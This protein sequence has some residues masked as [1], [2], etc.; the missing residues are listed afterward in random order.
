MSMREMPLVSVITATY[1]NFDHLKETMLSVF[2]QDYPYIE[3]IIT[4]DGSVDFQK[5]MVHELI[6]KENPKHVDFKLILNPENIGTVKNLNGAYKSAHG[7]YYINLSCGDV[8]FNKT[9]ICTS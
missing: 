2:H 7:E 6:I 3:Y 4:D 8:F 5:D 9:V 1:K